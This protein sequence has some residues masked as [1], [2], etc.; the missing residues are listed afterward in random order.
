MSNIETKTE[1]VRCVDKGGAHWLTEGKVYP[2]RSVVDDKVEVTC[3]VGDVIFYPIECFVP[4]TADEAKVTIE[5]PVTWAQ[6]RVAELTLDQCGDI[7]SL[8]DVV[9]DACT[10]ALSRAGLL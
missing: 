6:Y 10:V 1:W 5:V 2:V 3:D 9:D 4:A 7:E 8:D